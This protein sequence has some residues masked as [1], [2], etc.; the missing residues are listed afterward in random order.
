MKTR[1]FLF[2]VILVFIGSLLSTC[3]PKHDNQFNSTKL[4]F[5]TEEIKRLSTQLETLTLQFQ[6][7]EDQKEA[8][9]E[10]LL[11]ENREL[12]LQ[13]LEAQLEIKKL[14]FKIEELEEE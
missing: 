1:S 6:V 12:S 10:T 3:Q 11:Q 7:L 8:L 4:D 14:Y 13:L 5:H 2:L 9:K